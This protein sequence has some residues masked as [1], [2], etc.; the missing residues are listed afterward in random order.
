MDSLLV[1]GLFSIAAAFALGGLL[2]VAGSLLEW[3]TN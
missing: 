3:D 1:D 2:V